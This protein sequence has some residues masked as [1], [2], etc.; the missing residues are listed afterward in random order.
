MSS[1][2]AFGMLIQGPEVE[3]YLD[4]LFRRP[5]PPSHTPNQSKQIPRRFARQQIRFVQL[6][7]RQRH[8][9]EAVVPFDKE[10]VPYAE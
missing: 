10:E 5:Q 6:Q 7:Y 9:K 4:E 3:T 2:I 8:P 1:P